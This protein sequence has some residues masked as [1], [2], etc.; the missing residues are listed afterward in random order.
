ASYSSRLSMTKTWQG[1]GSIDRLADKRKWHFKTC[2]RAVPEK[3]RR[4]RVFCGHH[5]NGGQRCWRQSGRTLQFAQIIRA[6]AWSHHRSDLAADLEWTCCTYALFQRSF[7][8]SYFLSQDQGPAC[9]ALEH[10]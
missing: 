8:S 6:P 7:P 9:L 1:G 10:R 3:G 2:R 5:H 4:R